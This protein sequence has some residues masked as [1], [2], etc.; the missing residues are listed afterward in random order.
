M[1]YT[2]TRR[3]TVNTFCYMRLKQAGLHM[4]YTAF[5][6]NW[7]RLGRALVTRIVTWQG[8]MEDGPGGGG[9]YNGAI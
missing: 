7:G 5:Q 9:T 1:H 6:H 2:L 4:H 3:G 8:I